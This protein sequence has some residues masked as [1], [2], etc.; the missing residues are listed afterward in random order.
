MILAGDRAHRRGGQLQLRFAAGESKSLR[1]QGHIKAVTAFAEEVGCKHLRKRSGGRE[2]E[3]GSC[4]R[5]VVERE[6]K[7]E[8]DISHRLDS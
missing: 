5:R 8:S 2:V 3:D 4:G 1:V 7:S 6:M